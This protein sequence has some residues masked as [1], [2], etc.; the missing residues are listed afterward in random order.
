MDPADGA[1]GLLSRY[2]RGLKPLSLVYFA[3]FFLVGCA[4]A[5]YR[6]VSLAS[7]LNST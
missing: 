4:L 2:V 6:N 5:R 1:E 3:A 7:K